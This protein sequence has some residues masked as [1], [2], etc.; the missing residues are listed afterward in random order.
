MAGHFDVKLAYLVKVK[1]HPEQ[2]MVCYDRLT[3]ERYLK[4]LPE[5]WKTTVTHISVSEYKEG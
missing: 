3:L 2:T 5:N 1:F 4:G